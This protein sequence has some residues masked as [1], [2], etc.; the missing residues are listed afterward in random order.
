MSCVTLRGKADSEIFK[1]WLWL[2]GIILLLHVT[3]DY[4][5]KYLRLRIK[6]LKLLLCRTKSRTEPFLQ[7]PGGL[8]WFCWMGRVA[9]GENC[10]HTVTCMNYQAQQ[11]WDPPFAN[12]TLSKASHCPPWLG[13]PPLCRRTP[14]FLPPLLDDQRTTAVAV[15]VVVVYNQLFMSDK[16]PKNEGVQDSHHLSVFRPW[17]LNSSK[18]FF[19]FSMMQYHCH[20]F[21]K[22]LQKHTFE[23]QPLILPYMH[24]WVEEHT[25]QT[26]RCHQLSV[27]YLSLSISVKLWYDECRR[28]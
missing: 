27:S 13:F 21:Y 18:P 14:C 7:E 12:T 10:L 4:F 20:F 11:W 28:R 8:C 9:F 26:H 2:L 5:I 23:D 1:Q 19:R 3:G 16:N 24:C 25:D 15:V 22:H 17:M 6:T